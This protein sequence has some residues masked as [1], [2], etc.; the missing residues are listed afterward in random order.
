MS[1]PHESIHLDR[2]LL[3]RLLGGARLQP[4]VALLV[5]LLAMRAVLLAAGEHQDSLPLSQTLLVLLVLLVVLLIGATGHAEADDTGVSWRYYLPHRLPWEEIDQISLVVRGVG[6]T[7]LRH[8][9]VV[10]AAGHRHVITPA[11]VAGS[12]Q[13]RF[14]RELLAAAAARGIAVDDHWAV[15]D[16]WR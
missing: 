15:G 6:L 16:H 13:I 5:L 14:G 8:L 11:W 9:L 12:G 10:R 1:V 2:S 7:S 4:L 3:G